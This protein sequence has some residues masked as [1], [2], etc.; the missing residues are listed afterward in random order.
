M[1]VPPFIVVRH[2]L[3]PYLVL[4]R[5]RAHF[6]A[7][8]SFCLFVRSPYDL[9]IDRSNPPPTTA[10]NP[11]LLPSMLHK[12]IMAKQ[13]EHMRMPK[14]ILVQQKPVRMLLPNSL[15]NHHRAAHKQKAKHSSAHLNRLTNL[16]NM[17]TRNS[18]R[19]RDASTVMWVTWHLLLRL[20]RWD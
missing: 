2:D 15:A 4:L 6:L 1:C 12:P 14:R 10:S 7:F 8:C 13:P 3:S 16:L 9:Y 5:C 17:V 20:I 18:L 19:H 11:P